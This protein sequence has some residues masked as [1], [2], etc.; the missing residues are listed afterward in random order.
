MIGLPP[1]E[2]ARAPGG[3]GDFRQQYS[4]GVSRPSE[5]QQPPAE[6]MPGPASAGS[7]AAFGGH[8]LNAA[9]AAMNGGMAAST[10]A[11]GS[12]HMMFSPGMAS[13]Q[14]SRAAGGPSPE[15]QMILGSMEKLRAGMWNVVNP[16]VQAQQAPMPQF[17]QQAQGMYPEQA[18]GN[19]MPMVGMPASVVPQQNIYVSPA[20]AVPMQIPP[21]PTRSATP[22]PEPPKDVPSDRKT[23]PSVDAHVVDNTQRDFQ[24][25]LQTIRGQLVPELRARRSG[26]LSALQSVEAQ[27]AEIQQRCLEARRD[28]QAEFEALKAHLSSV[29]NLKLAVLGRERDERARLADGIDETLKCV[30]EAASGKND[31]EVVANFIHE[32][33][34]LHAKAQ[35]LWSR[36]AALPQVEVG[37]HD[38]PFEARAKSDKLRKFAVM[39]RLQYAKD[40]CLWHLELQRRHFANEALEAGAC[41]QHLESLLDRYAEELAYVCYFCAERFSASAANTRCMYNQSPRF[42]ADPRVPSHIWGG[43]THFWVP[44]NPACGGRTGVDLP[45]SNGPLRMRLGIDDYIE[46]MPGPSGAPSRHSTPP[47]RVPSNWEAPYGGGAPSWSEGFAPPGQYSPR[48]ADLLLRKIAQACE[49]SGV[50]IRSAF[51]AFDANGDGFISPQEFKHAL[52]QLKVGASDEDVAWLLSRLDLNADGMVSYEEFLARHFN[53]AQDPRVANVG[54]A[55]VEHFAGHDAAAQSL[56]QRVARVFRD[57]GVPL[58]QAFALFDADGDGIISRQDLLEAFRLMHL[59][60]SDGDVERMMKDID[61]NEDGKVS[62]HEF[63]N[64]LM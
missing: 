27:I 57:R 24:K 56:W 54:P 30:E 13:L 46:A 22:P 63:I 49:R 44:C 8:N 35:S 6:Q 26:L 3:S 33:P 55:F 47:R 19:S 31:P 20:V 38:I 23:L 39:G 34:E 17:P 21:S 40:V 1:V 29:E 9:A 28:G 10:P 62:I 45:A 15:M 7:T 2:A 51:R 41:L 64:R 37:V 58:R 14:N 59:G 61:I 12:G 36:S 18:Q 4:F 52:S 60:L 25:K 5:S 43:G 53:A 11:A 48:S 42:E 32:F 16:P 50:D